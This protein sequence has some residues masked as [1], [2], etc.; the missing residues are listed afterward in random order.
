MTP[1]AR[2][3]AA[4]EVLDAWLD[5]VHGEKAL[6]T[7]ARGSRYAGSKDRAAVRDHV[8]AVLRRLESCAI[9]GGGRSGRALMIGLCRLDAVAPE[10]VFTGQGY[11]PEPLGDGDAP[12]AE[13]GVNGWTDIPNWLHDPLRDSLGADADAIV[14]TLTDRAPLYL[15]I[16][17]RKFDNFELEERLLSDGISTEKTNLLSALKVAEGGR[18]VRQCDAYQSGAVEIQDLSVQQACARVNWPSGGRILDYC[19]GGGGKALAIAALSDARVFVHDV[20]PARM[21]DIPARAERAGVQLH[22]FDP[23]QLYDLV[24]CDVPCS[25]SGIWRRDPEAKWR[26]TADML[27]DLT[28]TQAT[29]LDEAALLLRPGGTLVY[30]TCSF[31]Q[32]ENEAQIAAFQDRS[33]GWNLKQTARFSPLNA[34]DGFFLAELT[35]IQ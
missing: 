5:G 28:K 3:A 11:A 35:Q 27:A 34:S 2:V 32:A 21:R 12:R 31:L 15:R 22:P 10:T 24:L 19:A 18:R 16:N 1:G 8:F 13:T 6:S 20:N 30:M 25:G 4:I 29:I 26:L 23:A 33:F 17:G 9:S 7:W 14:Q